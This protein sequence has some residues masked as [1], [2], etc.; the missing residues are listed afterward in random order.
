MVEEIDPETV[1][2]FTDGSCYPN[3]DGH[4]GWAVVGMFRD[5]Y[6]E[7]SGYLPHS[8]NNQ[9]ELTAIL[10]ALQ[11]VKPT[12]SPILLVTDSQYCY[13]AVTLWVVG[14][15]KNGWRNSV[16]QPVQNRELIEQIVERLD[17]FRAITLMTVSWTRGHAKGVTP[18]SQFNERAD[19]LAGEARKSRIVVDNE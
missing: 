2:L 5:K 3:P 15:K 17:F 19:H 8:S 1:I 13:R 18:F 11:M 9:A 4:G 14:W 12:A 6:V 16:G 10:K 7:K